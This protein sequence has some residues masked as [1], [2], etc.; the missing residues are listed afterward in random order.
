MTDTDDENED[1]EDAP[2]GLQLNNIL[3]YPARGSA[4]MFTHVFAFVVLQAPLLLLNKRGV[5]LV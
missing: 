3:P 5:A 4:R 2:T 1:V